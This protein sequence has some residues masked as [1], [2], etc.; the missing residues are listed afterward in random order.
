MSRQSIAT[1]YADHIRL[2]REERALLGRSILFCLA[3]TV[4]SY[5]ALYL[6]IIGV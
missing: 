1:F 5:G 6:A 3:L 4:A 2:D